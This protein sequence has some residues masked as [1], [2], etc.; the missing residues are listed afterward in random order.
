M[1]VRVVTI[2]VLLDWMMVRCKVSER[3]VTT[4]KKTMTIRNGMHVGKPAR[5]CAAASITL[6]RISVLKSNG[7]FVYIM[8]SL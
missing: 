4:A 7:P 5:E 6:T 8:I 3:V 2:R 1:R